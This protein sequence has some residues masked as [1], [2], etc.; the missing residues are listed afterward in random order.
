MRSATSEE[1]PL[2]F[3]PNNH[4]LQLLSHHF[5]ASFF[6]S[7]VMK[8]ISVLL[9]F[10]IISA[11]SPTGT[12]LREPV[13]IGETELSAMLIDPAYISLH[14]TGD[15]P[16]VCHEF[17]YEFEGPE[18]GLIDVTVYSTVSPAET[19]IQ[20]LQSFDEIV[21][22]PMSGQPSGTY[23]IYLNGENVGEIEFS[24]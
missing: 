8:Y 3:L 13:Y 9:A 16:T 20:G 14:I 1:S 18:N 4:V 17:H 23:V 22:I 11:C 21:E 12:P 7:A 2:R 15:L 24:P 19:C 5:G 10:L 6:E